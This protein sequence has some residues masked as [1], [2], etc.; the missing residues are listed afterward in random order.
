MLTCALILTSTPVFASNPTQ[1]P[2]YEIAFVGPLTGPQGTFTTRLELAARLAVNQ[3]NARSSLPFRLQFVAYDTKGDPAL[4]RVIDQHLVSR[5]HLVAVVGPTT[6]EDVAIAG[7]LFAA[8]Q[9]AMVTPSAGAPS[10]ATMGYRNFFRVV[11]DDGAQGIADGDFLVKARGSRRVFVVSDG[12]AYGSAIALAVSAQVTRDGGIVTNEVA[13]TTT[14]CAAGPGDAAQ[15]TQIARAA[16]AS[17]ATSVF[18]GGSYCDF[19][20]LLTSLTNAGYHGVILS[21]DAVDSSAL[22]RSVAMTN[23]LDGVYLSCGCVTSTNVAFNRAFARVA[24]VS[25]ARANDAAEAYDATNTIIAAMGSLS[26]VTRAALTA[27]L[28]RVVYHGITGSVSFAANGNRRATVT[29]FAQLQN[30]SIVPIGSA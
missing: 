30:G 29:S 3:A 16:L 2:L 11:A 21:D 9:L 10:L 25:A 8:S 17:Q 26:R 18:Y 19:G 4:S 1:R 5:P 13:P 20:L 7:P 12:S 14:Q 6:N 27:A 23:N 24:H 15:Y 28:R 22:V